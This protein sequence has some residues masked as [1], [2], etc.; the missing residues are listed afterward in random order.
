MSEWVKRRRAERAKATASRTPEVHRA[1][2]DLFQRLLNECAN[3]INADHDANRS[4]RLP[5]KH[6]QLELSITRDA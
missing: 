6:G 2:L 3:A 4:E 5:M 1:A